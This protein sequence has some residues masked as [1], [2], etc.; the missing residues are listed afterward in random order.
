MTSISPQW[1]Y[2]RKTQWVNFPLIWPLQ[3]LPLVYSILFETLFSSISRLFTLLIFLLSLWPLCLNFLNELLCSLLSE[4]LLC[5]RCMTKPS[6]YPYT[7]PWWPIHSPRCSYHPRT[8]IS[9]SLPDFPIL[10]SFE[11]IFHLECPTNKSNP[12]RISSKPAPLSNVPYSMINI[13]NRI[14]SQARDLGFVFSPPLRLPHPNYHA[15][16]PTSIFYFF[17]FSSPSFFF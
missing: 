5:C 1:P 15:T 17:Y 14:G 10:I 7:L 4:M 11:W 16:L 9:V 8:L 13:T 6:S 2:C 3:C 12:K